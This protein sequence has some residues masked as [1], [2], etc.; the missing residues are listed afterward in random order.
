MKQIKLYALL[1]FASLFAVAC[2]DDDE[3]PSFSHDVV[4]INEGNFSA[5]DGSIS[6]YNYETEK[7]E[8][9]LFEAANDFEFGAIIQS[10]TK[11]NG[12][13][14]VVGNS[15]D[16]LVVV[17][18][19]D[20]L[21]EGTITTDL[22]IP[23]KFVAVGN[24]GYISN[25]G[26]QTPDYKYVDAFLTVV[27]LSSNTVTKKIDMPSKTQGLL[28]FEEKLYV[29]HSASNTISVLDIDTDKVVETIE[30]EERPDAM[31]LD[32]NNKIWVLCSSGALVQIDPSTNKVIKTIKEIT[33]FGYNEKLVINEAGDRL[34]FIGGNEIFTLGIDDTVA[35]EKGLVEVTTAY[36]VGI[37]GDKLF[38][39]DANAYS[40]PGTVY[41]YDLEGNEQSS[42]TTG[43]LPN[44]F[45]FN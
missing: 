19:E 32:K 41:I 5:A 15:T 38:V 37:N 17:N 31:V 39:G 40:G 27:D 10:V 25:W 35:P 11:Y 1:I 4:V 36:G 21:L 33:A 28:I 20:Y 43:F 2:G 16:E 26:T 24:K 9:G 7:V 34:Y 18:G 45:I 12:K 44:G 14:Y 8:N 6:G 22:A 23:Y 30:T 3:G 13:Y 29:T 42:F